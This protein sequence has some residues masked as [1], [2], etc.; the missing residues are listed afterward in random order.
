M[1]HHVIWAIVWIAI[2]V[3]FYVGGGLIGWIAGVGTLL[4]QKKPSV[5]GAAGSI[6]SGIVVAVLMWAFAVFAMIKC[7]LQIIAAVNS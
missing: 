7:V 2:A 4:A 3:A 1:E 5:G 6:F